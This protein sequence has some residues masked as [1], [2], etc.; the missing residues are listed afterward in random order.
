MNASTTEYPLKTVQVIEKEHGASRSRFMAMRPTAYVFDC[1]T[2]DS[3]SCTKALR[4][5]SGSDTAV[6]PRDWVNC[7][8][9]CEGC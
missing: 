2:D 8:V 9:S 3:E 7:G 1:E 5:V 4:V 6:H